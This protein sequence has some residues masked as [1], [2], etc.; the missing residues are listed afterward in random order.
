LGWL[1]RLI[2]WF[3]GST[4]IK[5]IILILLSPLFSIL[6]ESTEEKLTGKKFSFS[7]VQ[8]IKDIFRGVVITLRNLF[9]Q[10]LISSGLWLVTIFF[11]P[12]LFV[13]VPL[14]VIIGWYF[15]GFSIMDY[16]CERH[17]YSTAQSVTFINK[18][19][20]YMIGIGCVY[21]VFLALPLPFH[22]GDIIGIMFGPA[23]AV[24]GATM[25]FL[26]I[27]EQSQRTQLS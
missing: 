15:I 18:H 12:L 24:I 20:G 8:L 14:S 6:S 4:F 26:K 16:N 21:S 9:M 23:V 10:L 25:S 22:L 13:T 27:N 19:K 17:K 7:F 5:Y 1:L 3:I 2:V 11:P